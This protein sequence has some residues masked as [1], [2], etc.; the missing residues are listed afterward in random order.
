MTVSYQIVVLEKDIGSID[1]KSQTNMLHGH[2]ATKTKNNDAQVTTYNVCDII[3][4]QF[5]ASSTG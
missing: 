2:P 5:I 3:L 4:T 1:R